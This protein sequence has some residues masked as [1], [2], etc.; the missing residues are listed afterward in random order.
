MDKLK[1]GQPLTVLTDNETSFHN[2]MNFLNALKTHPV[3]EKDGTIWHIRAVKPAT[4]EASV[5]PD[6][7][8]SPS[9]TKPEGS[10]VVTIKSNTMGV[11]NDELGKLLIRGFINAMAE[12]DALPSHMIF[13]NSGVLLT[14]SG[15]DTSES[16]KKLESKGVSIVVCGT[17]VDFF[18]IKNQVAVGMISNMYH[19]LNLMKDADKVITP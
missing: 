2:L 15:T 1:P 10:Y 7:F 4:Q 9:P 16:L 6:A 11:G 3:S 18:E 12:M 5:D 8:C 19:I 13:Y 17:C 14:V